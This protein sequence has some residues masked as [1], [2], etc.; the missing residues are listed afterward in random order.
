METSLQLGYAIGR[1][2][3][4]SATIP[5]K[6]RRLFAKRAIN[7]YSIYG[8]FSGQ[9]WAVSCKDD[10]PDPMLWSGDQILAGIYSSALQQGNDTDILWRLLTAI[11]LECHRETN[12]GADG[13]PLGRHQKSR[14]GSPQNVAFHGPNPFIRCW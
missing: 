13:V 4:R 9:L 2:P 1:S 11:H 12:I 8:G 5:I 7:Q 6:G 14:S 10:L 3:S